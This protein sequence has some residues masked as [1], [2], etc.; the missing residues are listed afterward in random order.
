MQQLSDRRLDVKKVVSEGDELD[1]MS[2]TARASTSAE[3]LE[4]K[5]CT[6]VDITEVGQ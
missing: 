2:R 4:S 5:Y 6:I 3:L 1:K